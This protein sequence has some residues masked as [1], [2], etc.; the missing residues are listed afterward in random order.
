V[1]SR[2]STGLQRWPRLA[3]TEPTRIERRR[4]MPATGNA[5]STLISADGVA[6]ACS[7]ERLQSVRYRDSEGWALPAATAGL[8]TRA[9][10]RKLGAKGQSLLLT[11]MDCR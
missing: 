5:R 7:A 1:D 10:P 3:S 2:H 11:A 4:A 9:S 8:L 6:T